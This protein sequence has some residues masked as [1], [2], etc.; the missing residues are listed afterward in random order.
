SVPAT[1]GESFGL[2]VLESLASGVPVV[3]PRHAA[4]PELLEKAGGGILVEPDNVNALA[5]G[6]ELLFLDPAKARKVGLQGREAV[7]DYFSVGR[8]AQNVEGVLAEV[9]IQSTAR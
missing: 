8:M 1:Y 5:D 7:L 3:Q 2:Y 9:A 4:F 6:I